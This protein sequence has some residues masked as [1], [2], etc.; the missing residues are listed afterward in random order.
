M[1]K[2]QLARII[3][4][5]SGARFIHIEPRGRL[6]VGDAMRRLRAES[7]ERISALLEAEQERLIAEWSKR[8]A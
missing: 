6:R 5:R 8:G 1:T 4:I 3:A 2:I 7:A